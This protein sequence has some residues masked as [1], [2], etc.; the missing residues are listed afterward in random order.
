M[1]L[2]DIKD[3]LSQAP[4][5]D[6]F[7]PMK[8]YIQILAVP[9]RAEQ[10]REFTQAQ[11]IMLYLMKQLGNAILKDGSIISG[12]TFSFSGSQLTVSDGKI[13]MDG[14]VQ[15]FKEQTITVTKSGI[16][17]IGAKLIKSIVTEADDASLRDPAQGYANYGQPGGHRLKAE[18]QLTRNDDTAAPLYTF[19]NGEL[20][21]N[22]IKP[23]L[24]VITD[25]LARRTFDEAGNFKVDGLKVITS[26]YDADNILVT[27]EAGKAYIQGY[28][29]NRPSPA[30]LV[31]PKAQTVRAV[32]NE[33][34]IYQNGI[35]KYLLN[36]GNA[37]AITSVMGVVEVTQNI[38]RGSIGGGM[39]SIPKTPVVS[40]V[41]VTKGATTYQP[42]TDYQVVGD[43][44]DWSPNGQEPAIGATYTVKWRYNKTMILNG[45]YTLSVNT[46]GDSYIDFSPPGDDPVVGT[47]VL[48]DYE[49]YLA[50]HD[51]LYMDKNGVV[52]ALYGTSDLYE[53]AKP[54]VDGN[55]LSLSLG[56]VLLK[57]NSSVATVYSADTIT[58]VSMGD[59][60]AIKKRI[61]NLEFNQAMEN[62][63]NEAM[64][65]ESPTSLRGIFT[66]GFVGFSKADPAH[67][68]FSAAVD[69]ADN[70]LVLSSQHTLAI[71]AMDG[72][73]SSAAVSYANGQMYSMGF[74]E[75]YIATQN[76]ATNTMNVNPYSA[77]D[78][79]AFMRITPEV[80][81]WL[82]TSY[83]TVF[84][85]QVK[86]EN[87]A[88]W[89][90]WYYSYQ[91][92]RIQDAVSVTTKDQTVAY[93]RQIEI[94]VECSDFPAN[95][96]LL[97]GYI[98]GVQVNL[99]PLGATQ[100]GSSYGTVKAD[101]NGYLKA[102]FVIPY[103]IRTGARE[104]VLKN[105]VSS[106]SA[107][108]TSSGINRTVTT[109]IF[110]TRTHYS[111]VDPLA[112]SFQL[113]MD[114]VVTGVELFFKTKSTVNVPVTVQV[115]S[116]VN[117]YPGT[118]VLAEKVVNAAEVNVSPLGTTPT[119]VNFNIPVMC[120]KDVQY[121]FVVLT[122]S[123]EYNL[124]IARLGEK[125]VDSTAFMTSNPYG[126]GVMFSS[127]NALTWTAHQDA[128]LKFKLKGAVYT[129]SSTVQFAP[130]TGLDADSILL[131]TKLETPE[132]TT[133]VLEYK[134]ND[135]SLWFPITALSARDLTK[136][137]TKITLRARMTSTNKYM[138]P[139]ISGDEMMFVAS[140]TSVSGCY[141]SKLVETPQTYTTVR[142]IV[143]AKVPAGTAVSVQLSTDDATWVTGNLLSTE[144][145]DKDFSR[146]TYE[147]TIPDSGVSTKFRARVNLD[148]ST[149]F[150]KPAVRKLMNIIK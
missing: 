22:P 94:Q 28:E 13:Y 87:I 112:Q 118:E 76:Y 150:V 124:F 40:V 75:E 83:V 31:L 133:C 137:G 44:I 127:A 85:E 33:P 132:G 48:V 121:C 146:Y 57:P 66:D 37:R 139:F 38:T 74:T 147:Y 20:Q 61:D 143:E 79:R 81:S 106:A 30:R 72:A 70:K 6:D 122:T 73:T 55:R 27:V 134:V 63:D 120:Q 19:I 109:S 62:L 67:S 65:G 105:P 46:N 35:Q 102:K 59:I 84:Q 144:P 111:P 90:N 126:P 115:R 97:T 82:D 51:R 99:T 135:D 29:V 14:I 95:T 91:N 47:T 64:S 88:G 18:V 142:Q 53:L 24:T 1:N 41:S 56:T 26:S 45:D 23:E 68:L 7:D 21:T 60:Q 140:K 10:A 3:V 113:S 39:D 101:A 110:R 114:R 5:S 103:G 86:Y 78:K 2:A 123:N 50:R 58:R 98:D 149:R 36:N 16:E 107:I 12:M 125:M 54:P 34:K 42:G 128:D 32:S 100:A 11:T 77:F 4:Y 129:T 117:G 8:Q 92:D 131:D 145:V 69:L 93:A 15:D 136:A 138:S 43:R 119:V 130:I 148:T 25:L 104:I 71:P 89:W 116:M 80:D 108:F 17:I 52:S 141:V 96:D 9:G 49:F